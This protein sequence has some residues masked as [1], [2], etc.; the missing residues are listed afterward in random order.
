VSG[1]ASARE[2]TAERRAGGAGLRGRP[3]AAASWRAW[4]LAVRPRTLP[5]AVAPV[6]VGTALAAD[7]G[8]A[9]A[10]PAAAALAVALLLQVAANLA[11]DVFDFEKGADTEERLGPPRASQLGLLTPRQLRG[12]TALA[13]GA[14][15]LPGLYLVSLGGWPLAVAGALALLAAVAYTGGPFPL[16]YHGL[17]DVAVFAFFGVVAV[18]GSYW[19]Q[20]LT[21]PGAVLAASVPMGALASAILAVNNLRDVATDARAG[22]RTLA[23]RW[24]A[25]AARA[26]YAL[27]LTAAYGTPP[28][29]VAAAA[30]PVGALLPLLSLPWALALA[31]RVAHESGPALN[32]VLAATARLELGFAVLLAGGWLL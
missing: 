12:G 18:C 31:R 19:V 10:A 16:G 26:Q 3:A 22:K 23:V 11:N 30:A 8:Q 24:G 28:L 13:L 20:T 4:L 2:A 6:L 5:V 15:A 7:A 1:A 21:L 25:R 27:L 14:A 9:A 32:P 29:L 17:G